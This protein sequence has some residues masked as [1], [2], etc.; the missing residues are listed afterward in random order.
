MSLVNISVTAVATK[1]QMEITL[2]VL[3]YKIKINHKVH[4]LLVKESYNYNQIMEPCRIHVVINK[5][6]IET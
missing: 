2:K 1:I 5:H 6:Q 4:E 3:Y